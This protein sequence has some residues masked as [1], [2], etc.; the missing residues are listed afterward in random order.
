MMSRPG[1][2]IQIDVPGGESVFLLSSAELESIEETLAL[3][4]DPDAME[5]IR[6]GVNDIN[7]GDLIDWDRVK[8][9]LAGGDE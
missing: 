2:R 4:A 7:S 3:L 8:Q 9:G 5:T 6:E 1:E